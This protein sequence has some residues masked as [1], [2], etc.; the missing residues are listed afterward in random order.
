LL[1]QKEAKMPFYFAL[2]QSS[3]RHCSQITILK[4]TSKLRSAYQ[5]VRAARSTPGTLP[6]RFFV[7]FYDSNLKSRQRGSTYFIFGFL[8]SAE[9]PS[10]KHF[11]SKETSSSFLWPLRKSERK[12]FTLRNKP[13]REVCAL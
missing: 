12:R 8:R 13:L 10:K 5:A 6:L 9:N 3:K 4:T 1:A 2:S 11:E 7:V